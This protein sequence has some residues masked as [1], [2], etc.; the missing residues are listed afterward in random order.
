[1]KKYLT[2]LFTIYSSVLLNAQNTSL[3]KLDDVRLI[4]NSKIIVALTN[5]EEINLSLKNTVR[6]FWSFCP[7]S[8]FMPE[9]EA[10]LKAEKEQGFVVM[11]IDGAGS[12]KEWNISIYDKDENTLIKNQLPLGHGYDE[13]FAFGLFSMQYLCKTMDESNSKNNLRWNSL[14]KVKSAELKTKKLYILD[15]DLDSDLDKEKI[16]ENYQYPIEV[17]SYDKWKDAI[18]NKTEGV[19]YC[20]IVPF[21]MYLNSQSGQA[22]QERLFLFHYLVEAKSGVVYS[23]EKDHKKI[24]K[25]SIRDYNDVASKE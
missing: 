13:T 7:I 8:D 5:F 4:K 22:Q 6:N 12:D 23:I 21:I 18:L 9:K 10:F 19:A 20:I 1:M 3:V 24:K 16:K 17:V 2:L 11:K 15:S 14:Y 25:S